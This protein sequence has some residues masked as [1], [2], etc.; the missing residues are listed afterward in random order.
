M[1]QIPMQ[2]LK[3]KPEKVPIEEQFREINLGLESVRR[4]HHPTVN[5]RRFDIDSCDDKKSH[6]DS[7]YEKQQLAIDEG[8]HSQILKNTLPKIQVHITKLTKEYEALLK[9]YKKLRD[10]EK[11]DQDKLRNADV[12][13]REIFAKRDMFE[14][15]KQSMLKEVKTIVV[16]NKKMKQKYE[17]RLE[18][19]K[20]HFKEC[21]NILQNQLD[22]ERNLL[23]ETN[24]ILRHLENKFR[25]TVYQLELCEDQRKLLV[26][27][28]KKSR[29]QFRTLLFDTVKKEIKSK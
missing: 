13:I 11:T 27:E 4:C 17:E 18:R 2:T 3:R 25:E 7:E 20:S 6:F 14:G 23:N 9:E 28:L 29:D 10:D 5:A 12:R 19:S 16:E 26:E 22:N 21:T 15:I 8:I 24:K 1:D